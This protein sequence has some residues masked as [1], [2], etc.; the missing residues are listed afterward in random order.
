MQIVH[1]PLNYQTK[2]Q[3]EFID[4]TDDLKKLIKSLH[5]KDGIIT[6]FVRHTTTAIKI[7]ESEEGF[8]HDF[9]NFIKTL[10]PNEGKYKHNDLENRKPHTMCPNRKE[11]CL[12]G[13]SHCQQMLIGTASET[14]PIIKGNLQLGTWQRVF[15][16]ELDKPRKRE[17][18]ATVIGDID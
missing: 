3:L 9:K 18:I 7:N 11:E 2:K 17:V 5:I 13:H 16:I 4:I 15:L 8:H 10:L 1:H 6:I 12:N 14:I